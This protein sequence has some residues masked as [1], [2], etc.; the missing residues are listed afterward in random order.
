MTYNIFTEDIKPKTVQKIVSK[1]FDGFTISKNIGFWKG[2]KEKSI[3]IEIILPGR[4]LTKIRNL[5]KEI[6]IALNQEAVI[7]N[8]ITNHNEMI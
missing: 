2:Q 8:E 7:F 5:A 6:K 1:Y 4:H 3:K